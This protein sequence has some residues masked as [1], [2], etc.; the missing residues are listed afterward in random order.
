MSTD[1]THVPPSEPKT[2]TQPPPPK[3]EP[4]P[5]SI[6]C[7]QP[8]GGGGMTM[9]LLW[10]RFRRWR[11]KTFHSKYVAAMKARLKGDPANIPVEVV[12]SRD[13]KYYR[14]V[15]NCWFDPTDDLFAWRK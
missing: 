8:G 5:F 10:G 3:A 7:I 2:P 11:L 12:D 4:M 9:E 13:L 15:A 6:Y 1:A 14:N